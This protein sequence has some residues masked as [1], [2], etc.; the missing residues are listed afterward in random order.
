MYCLAVGFDRDFLKFPPGD[1]VQKFV[2]L[3]FCS[4][5][6]KGSW[7]FNQLLP[8]LMTDYSAHVIM[9]LKLNMQ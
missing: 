2:K 3:I 6:E 1:I 5:L 8:A 7:Q 9:Q 4:I